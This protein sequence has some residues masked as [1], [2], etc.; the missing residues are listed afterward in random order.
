MKNKRGLVI[1]IFLLV[2]IVCAWYMTNYG[3]NE[4]DIYED[5][6]PAGQEQVTDNPQGS[7]DAEPAEQPGGAVGE[8]EQTPDASADYVD[9]YFRSAKLLNQHY[10]KHGK[11]MGFD[12]PE[13]YEK[14]ASDVINNPDALFKYEKEDGD[15]VYYVV[16]TN[17]FA[18]LSTDGYIR[19]YFLPDS[20]KKY[21][22][23]Q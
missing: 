14:A 20:G 4:E 13:E 2:C 11:D 10:D 16:E 23:K 19:T 18:V 3:F 5:P 1:I 12:S 17:E 21:F 6:V 15:E 8:P 22:D 9:Y 7:Q